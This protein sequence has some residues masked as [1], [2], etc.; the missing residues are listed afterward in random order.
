VGDVT[1]KRLT[2]HPV[3]SLVNVGFMVIPAPEGVEVP[4]VQGETQ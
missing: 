1:L 3:L 4:E 2:Y